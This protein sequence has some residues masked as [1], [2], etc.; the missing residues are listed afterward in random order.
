ML[1]FDKVTESLKM[2][3]FFETLCIFEDLCI[4][5]PEYYVIKLQ[6][7]AR[8]LATTSKLRYFRHEFTSKE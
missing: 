3:T 4:C 5:S 2:E 7:L 8:R 6:R 1:S